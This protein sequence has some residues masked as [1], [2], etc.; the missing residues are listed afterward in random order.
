[1]IFPKD[2]SHCLTFIYGKTLASLDN[3]SKEA[4]PFI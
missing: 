4:I 3:L 1:M 2:V